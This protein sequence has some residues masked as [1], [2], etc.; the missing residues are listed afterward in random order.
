M[1][2]PYIRTFT[3][4][5]FYP[6]NP[7]PD[8]IDILDIAA[9]LSKMPRYSGQTPF[10]YSVAQHSVHVSNILVYKE[11]KIAGLLHDASEAYIADIPSPIKA[12]LP[13]YRA[14]ENRIQGAI[15]KAL[16]IDIN[17][18]I[19]RIVHLADEMMLHCEFDLFFPTFYVEDLGDRIEDTDFEFWGSRPDKDMDEFLRVWYSLG[20]I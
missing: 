3:G 20:G 1:S 14:M 17:D 5:K 2:E 6:L 12:L 4:K 10:A 13:D 11:D 19:M 9:G 16:K 8:Q 15:F 7:E 18:E